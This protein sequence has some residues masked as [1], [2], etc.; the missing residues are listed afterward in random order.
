MSHHTHSELSH[1]ENDL[2]LVA[3]FRHNLWANL[4]LFD[5]CATLNEQQLAA[6]VPG[7]Y[8]TIYDTLSHIVRSEKGY[9]RR[10]SGREP[11]HPLSRENTPDIATLRFHAKNSGEGLIEVAANVRPSDAKH[12]PW[13]D[14]EAR[15]VPDGILLAQVINHA[16][17]HRAQIMTTLTQLGIEPP[18]LSGWQYAEEHVPPIPVE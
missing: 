15:M 18:E 12:V 4:R 13:K 8:G 17:E 14:G 2:P 16:T 10:L 3:L 7:T 5:V 11:E 9:L 6:S 1:P